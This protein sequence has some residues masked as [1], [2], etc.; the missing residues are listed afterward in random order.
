MRGLGTA[1]PGFVVRARCLRSSVV[2][3]VGIAH[4]HVADALARCVQV[5]PAAFLTDL[6]QGWSV[7]VSDRPAEPGEFTGD[8]HRDDCLALATLVVQPTPGAV[9]AL[10]GLPGE[11][12]RVRWL[13]F[14]AA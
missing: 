4:S 11:R 9:Q 2:P 10:L 7:G 1:G 8:S 13:A 14:L 3:C 5:V 12:D 6:V